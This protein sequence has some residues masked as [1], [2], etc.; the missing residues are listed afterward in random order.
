MGLGGGCFCFG[1]EDS[2]INIIILEYFIKPENI[3]IVV[4]AWDRFWAA[5]ETQISMRSPTF[6]AYIKKNVSF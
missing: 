4:W 6:P 1:Q 2:P 3:S 5:C